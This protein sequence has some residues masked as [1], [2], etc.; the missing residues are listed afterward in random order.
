MIVMRNLLTIGQAAEASGLSPD[1]I[2]YYEREGV[3]PRVQRGTNSY[4]GYPAEHIETLRFARRLREL[5]LAPAAMAGL[6]RLFHDGTCREMRDALL[7]SCGSAVATVRARRL[8]LERVEAQLRNVLDGLEQLDVDHRLITTV[9]PC[10]C[11]AVIEQE[12]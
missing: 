1:T 7:E 6:I 11:I 2:R 3:L 10:A 12:G 4:R 9:K 5:G 8:E